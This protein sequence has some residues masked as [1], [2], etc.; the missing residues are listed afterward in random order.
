MVMSIE[1]WINTA[2]NTAWF[3]AGLAWVLAKVLGTLFLDL[4][5]HEDLLECAWP[6]LGL[7][8]IADIQ[9]LVYCVWQQVLLLQW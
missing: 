6:G 8:G 5:T 4:S 1:I 7:H 9:D 3:P 2:C